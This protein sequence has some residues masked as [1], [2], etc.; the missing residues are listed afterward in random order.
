METMH[1]KGF[2]GS[3]EFSI[4]DSCY[5][6]RITGINDIISYEGNTREELEADFKNAVDDYLEDLAEAKK[7][8]TA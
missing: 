5:W 7:V 4:A 8:A 6:G 1:Y 2:Y 3:I